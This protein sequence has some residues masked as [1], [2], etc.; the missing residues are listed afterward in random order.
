MT[1]TMV[2][3]I[4]NNGSVFIWQISDPT[5]YVTRYMVFQF[6]FRVD[7]RK[8]DQM[9]SYEIFYNSNWLEI[10]SFLMHDMW[11]N[12]VAELVN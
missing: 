7:F 3:W 2:E 9:A 11:I 10:L 1:D 12:P 8:I 6:E 5:T 4:L